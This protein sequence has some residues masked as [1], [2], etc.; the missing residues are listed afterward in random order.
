MPIDLL[1]H[2]KLTHSRFNLAIHL[3]AP[4]FVG[5][6]TLEG[7]VH[8]GIDGGPFERR[9]KSTPGLSLSR[10]SVT[11]VGLERCRGRQDM[12]RALS[13]DL[14]DAAHPPPAS[15]APDPGPDTTW[16]VQPSNST[17]P[18]RLDLPVLMGPPPYRSKKVS[19][20]YW[21]CISADFQ[22]LGKK[23]SVRQS[24]EV[25]VL[26]VH[27]RR[28]FAL[29][30]L[31]TLRLTQVAAEKALVNL[32]DPLVAVDEM[33]MSKRYITQTVKLTAGLHRQTWISGYP[34][35]VDIHIENKSSRDIRKV[36]LQLDKTTLFH[37][38]SAP[39]TDAGSADVL[40]LPDHRETEIVV[41]KDLADGFHGVRSLSQDFRTCQ[42]E[43]PIGL[44]S[45]ETGMWFQCVN[46]E[47]RSFCLCKSLFEL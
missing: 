5:G 46:F 34:V 40:R 19:I 26:T 27:D 22:I 39:S 14:I 9:R 16:D 25:A 42:L 36:E 43:L 29:D 11:L 32:S 33:P 38:Y 44:V 17:L 20:S 12:F 3:S 8:V 37:K 6:A 15:M 23:H 47:R 28:C 4:I 7:E 45:I 18:F 41:R 21:L 24:R 10:I 2:P 1:D 31:S 35:F 13:C 30:A